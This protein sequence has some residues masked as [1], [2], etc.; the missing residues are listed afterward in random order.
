MGEVRWER[1]EGRGWRGEVRWERLEGRGWRGEVRWEKLEYWSDVERSEIPPLRE[2]I[3]VMLSEVPHVR[4]PDPSGKSR[5]CGR[6]LEYW[7]GGG[8]EGWK[9]DGET[10][11]L[12]RFFGG[13]ASGV[14][15]GWSPDSYQR[16]Y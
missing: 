13:R 3:G 6:V 7:S 16:I 10:H 8:L 14:M 2:S 1:L 11:S 15:E 9:W 5:H 12:P 4:D